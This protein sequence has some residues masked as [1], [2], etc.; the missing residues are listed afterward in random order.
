[1]RIA[2]ITPSL[3][4]GGYEKVIIA[5]ANEL[6]KRGHQ[7]DIL[8]G[9][10]KG[11]LIN[12]IDSGVSIYDFQ[13]RARKFIIPLMKYLKKNHV[14]ILYCPFRSYNS[15]G[16]IAKKISRVN[17]LVYATQHGFQKDRTIE[18]L[19]KGRIIKHADRL[20][21]VTQT[22][23]KYEAKE[24]NIDVQKFT[25]LNNPVYDN[26]RSIPQ[27]EHLWFADD[28][29]IIAVCGRIAKDKGTVFCIKILEILNRTMAVRMLVLGDG[30]ELEKCKQLTFDLHIEEQV[31]FLGYV[32]NPMGYMQNCS[33]LL[34]T[35]LE[36]GFG[37]II[38]EAL[39][40]NIPVCTTNCTGPLYIIKDGK[41]GVN[42]GNVCDEHFLETAADKVLSI[43]TGKKKFKG[44]QERAAEFEVKKATD[45]LLNLSNKVKNN[46]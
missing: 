34:H 23:A 46:E 29:P 10:K 43:L 33:L 22:V 16:V 5:Y 20:I 9:F 1:M 3:T 17:T 14:D 36:E 39:A 26:T 45:M 30:P 4:M 15:I 11:E 18:K 32:D 19:I 35:A 13:A 8:C 44:L 27:K 21:A 25:V 2:F 12:D 24:M 28:V 38:V 37:N 42:L 41:Y 7:V 40:V 6:N 31:D